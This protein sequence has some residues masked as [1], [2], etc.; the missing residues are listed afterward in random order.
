EQGA[1]EEHVAQCDA[2]CRFLDGLPQD[3]LSERLRAAGTR[4]DHEVV[5][6]P[7]V[8]SPILPPPPELVEHPRYEIVR[9]LGRG[10]MGVVYLAR[11]RVMEREVAIKVLN[12]DLLRHPEAS[13]RFEREMKAAARLLHPNIVT[14]HDAETAGDLH[15]L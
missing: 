15:F 7:V 11:H 6:P 4:Q 1:I 13:R 14:A 12:P 8:T 5:A 3:T 9:C 2:C 10:G